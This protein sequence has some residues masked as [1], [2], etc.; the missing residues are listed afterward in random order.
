MAGPGERGRQA[1]SAFAA[2]AAGRLAADRWLY[3]A[4][5]VYTAIGVAL[6]VATDNQRM[7]A[8]GLY[9]GQWSK[10]FLFLMP[11]GAVTFDICFVIL[12]F[13]RRRRLAYRR[14]FSARRLAALACG[15]AL[16]MGFMVFQGTFTSIKNVL[17]VLNGGFPYDRLHADLDRALHFGQD[18]WRWIYGVAGFGLVRSIVEFNYNVLWF[19]LCFGALFFVATSPAASAVRVRYL[20]MFMIVWVVCGNVL[21]GLFL[22]AGPAYYGLVTGDMARF[23]EQLAFLSASDWSS[24]AASYQK[25]LWQLHAA[26]KAGFG[27]GISA[28]PSVH[29]GLITMNALFAAEYSRRLGVAAFAYVAFV[30]ASSVYLAWHY[31]IDGYVSILVVIAAY[32]LTRAAFRPAVRGAAEDTEVLQPS[33]ARASAA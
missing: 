7:L 26:D 16:L 13:E 11:L 21:A 19:I 5:A 4:I 22:S 29:V 2:Q 28:F 10:M 25:Y 15:V 18:P 24:S 20:T 12:R 3:A 1:I 31:A 14:V 33:R 17:P 9:V 23:G 32:W 8:H 30:C 27:G 6:L